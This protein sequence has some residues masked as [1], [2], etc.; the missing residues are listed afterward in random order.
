MAQNA[1]AKLLTGMLKREIIFAILASI[2]WLPKRHYKIIWIA[3]KY[4]KGLTSS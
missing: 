1:G 4:L 2:H 3:T